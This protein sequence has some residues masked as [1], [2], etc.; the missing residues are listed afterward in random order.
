ML[1]FNLK[2][3][4][5]SLSLRISFHFSMLTI[6]LISS[7]LWRNFVAKVELIETNVIIIHICSRRMGC[8]G[9]MIVVASRFFFVCEILSPK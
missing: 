2:M 4:N 8:Y 5:L 7:E 9:E 3:K 6:P 1:I